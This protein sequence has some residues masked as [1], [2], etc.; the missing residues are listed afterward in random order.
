MLILNSLHSFLVGALHGTFIA[1]LSYCQPIVER[2]A[3]IFRFTKSLN[4]S[5]HTN[6]NGHIFTVISD[7]SQS[8]CLNVFFLGAP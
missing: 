2:L 8:D 3:E 4:S 7:S 6:N 1:L 5:K